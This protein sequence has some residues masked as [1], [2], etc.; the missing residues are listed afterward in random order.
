[1]GIKAVCSLSRDQAQK[2]EFHFLLIAA[3]YPAKMT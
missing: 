2:P 3:R 1:M